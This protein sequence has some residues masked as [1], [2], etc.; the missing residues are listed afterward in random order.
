MVCL[1]LNGFLAIP[2]YIVGF[3][4]ISTHCYSP[5]SLGSL[6]WITEEYPE[7]CAAGVI[8]TLGYWN[9][10]FGYVCVLVTDEYPS[11]SL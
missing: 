6:S 5:S 4:Y 7:W 3:V 9:R 8:G 10:V 1:S 2:L 11:F